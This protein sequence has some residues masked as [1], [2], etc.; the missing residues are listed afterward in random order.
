MPGYSVPL[1]API[2][3]YGFNINTDRPITIAPTGTIVITESNT[4]TVVATIYGNA[5]EVSI[6]EG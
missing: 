6:K 2:N 3:Q 5:P 1:G 4:G